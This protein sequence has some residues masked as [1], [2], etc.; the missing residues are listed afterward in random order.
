MFSQW[1]FFDDAHRDFSAGLSRWLTQAALVDDEGDVQASCRA[2]VHA[3]AEGGWLR[4]C[5]PALYG[6]VRATLDIR[7]L[8]L[9]RE[10]LAYRSALADFA[11]AMQ[12]LGSGALTLFGNAELQRRYLPDVASGRRVA[13][14]A[15]SERDAGSDI[16]ALSTRAR[17]DGDWYV[18]DGEKCW[19]S[20]AGIADFYVLFARTGAEGPK[21]LTAFALDAT[22]HGCM[23][24]ERIETISPHPLGTLRVDDARVAAACRIGEEGEGFKIAL[25]TLDLFRTTVGAAAVGFARRALTESVEHAKTR[26]LFGVP[27]GRLQLTQGA[28][29][30]MATDV[31]ASA[32]LVYR[33]AWT[34]DMGAA[35]VTREAA[36]AKWFATEA[37]G[38]V[39]DRAVQLFGGRGVTRGEIVER[40]YRDVRALRIYEGAS[41]IQQVVIAK[42]VLGS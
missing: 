33:A 37:A 35:R 11:F 27:L 16:A 2:W 14:F 29:A 19:I 20:N 17:R 42:Q 39:C 40:L 28:I 9:A 1:P 8:C 24:G 36:M 10:K 26:A 4:A 6:G 34:K 31:D 7:T 12:G 18:I 22:T 5:V 41:E 13:A 21:G 3:L 23:V 25:A 32:L 38:R 30:A 15:L